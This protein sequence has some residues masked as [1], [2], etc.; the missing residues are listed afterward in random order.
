MRHPA[1]F[2]SKIGGFRTAEK[3]APTLWFQPRRCRWAIRSRPKKL[4]DGN[5]ARGDRSVIWP[6]SNA[7]DPG[8]N[9]QQSRYPVNQSLCRGGKGIALLNDDDRRR[10][11][12]VKA[13]R[14]QFGIPASLRG[15]VSPRPRQI[16]IASAVDKHACHL[17]G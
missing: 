1:I 3:E 10:L 17:S 7:E 13:K 8:Q 4:R 14:E 9:F 6:G 12:C 2:L 11:A 16:E 15:K 5:G